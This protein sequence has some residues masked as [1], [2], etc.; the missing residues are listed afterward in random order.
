[1]SQYI[2]LSEPQSVQ[3]REKH[4]TKQSIT[5]EWDPPAGVVDYYAVSCAQGTPS[6]DRINYTTGIATAS[7][8]G[9]SQ[10]GNDYSIS[11][12]SHSWD[13]MSEVAVKVITACKFD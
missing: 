8:V 13:K 9:L 4:S 1:M 5:A 6:D 10:P 12:T 11:V 3:L 7:C 2:Q